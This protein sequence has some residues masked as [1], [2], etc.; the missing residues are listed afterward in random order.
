MIMSQITPIY[1]FVPYGSRFQV[2]KDTIDL[3]QLP[4]LETIDKSF[5]KDETHLENELSKSILNMIGAVKI[6]PDVDDPQAEKIASQYTWKRVFQHTL[7]IYK[8]AVYQ[9]FHQ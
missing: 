8:E 7:S 3:I 4:P 9:K 2:K 5:Q 1:R 6:N